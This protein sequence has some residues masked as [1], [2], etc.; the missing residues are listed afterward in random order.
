MQGL[1][2]SLSLGDISHLRCLSIGPT[3][4]GII[5][6]DSRF[7]SRQQSLLS[8]KYSADHPARLCFPDFSA[9]VRC[10][11]CISSDTVK[12]CKFEWDMVADI[13]TVRTPGVGDR[14]EYLYVGD[15]E[16]SL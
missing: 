5:P 8:H 10:W 2:V 15:E 14:Q 7:Q 12:D 11:S 9:W 3:L 16:E 4:G 13:Y 1:A 6:D